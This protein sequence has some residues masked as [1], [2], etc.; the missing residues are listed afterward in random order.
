MYIDLS[1]SMAHTIGSVINQAL[2]LS[3][4]CKKVSIPFRVFG[5]SNDEKACKIL[6]ERTNVMHKRFDII[7]KLGGFK[8]HPNYVLKEYISSELRPADYKIAFNNLLMLKAIHEARQVRVALYLP[9]HAP[10]GRDLK[11][12]DQL[13]WYSVQDIGEGLSATPLNDAIVTSIQITND[14]VAK[15]KIENMINIFLSDGEDDHRSTLMYNSENPSSSGI[16][17]SS[18]TKVGSSILSGYGVRHLTKLMPGASWSTSNLL[19]FARRATGARYVGFFIL[20]HATSTM[21]AIAYSSGDYH[22]NISDVKSKFRRDGFITSNNFGYD[23]QFFISSKQTIMNDYDEE[24][25]DKWWEEVQKKAANK[26]KSDIT[27]KSIAKGFTDQQT[28]KQL[29]RIMLVEFTKAIA[30]AA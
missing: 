29:N 3:D 26:G 12:A 23:V 13:H 7:N 8:F 25:N 4:F 17:R 27:T 20:R 14:F 10:E 30:E 9:Y 1:G 5:F 16:D 18:Q 24:D 19:Q 15:Y 28:K 21:N 22:S 11:I 6:C 2:I